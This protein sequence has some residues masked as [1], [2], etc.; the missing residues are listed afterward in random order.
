M[1]TFTKTGGAAYLCAV[2]LACMGA[3]VGSAETQT[4]PSPESK[5]PAADLDQWP[6]WRGPLFNG[7][8]PHANPPTEWSETKNVRWKVALP[9]K[10]HSTPVVWGDRVFVTSAVPFGESFAPKYS[11]AP[12]GHDEE[13]ITHRHRFT[14]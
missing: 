14:L 8:A 3:A 5:P 4:N 13:P 10:G 9:G 6:Q 1:P 2:V 12:G 7:V 11:G